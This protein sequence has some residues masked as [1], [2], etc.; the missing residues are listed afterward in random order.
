[1]TWRS[2][3]DPH[4]QTASADMGYMVRYR[5]PARVTIGRALCP[6][7]ERAFV[8]KK[9]GQLHGHNCVRAAWREPMRSDGQ[10][11]LFAT[12]RL[13]EVYGLR[14]AGVLDDSGEQLTMFA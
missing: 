6:S 4:V 2:D 12:R 13:A 14:K 10:R 1:M 8:V 5:K 7:C 11:R 3:T 9:D